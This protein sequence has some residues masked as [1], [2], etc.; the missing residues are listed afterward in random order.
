MRIE[1]SLRVVASRCCHGVGRVQ[2]DRREQ[3]RD[4]REELRAGAECAR[5]LRELDYPPTTI[6]PDKQGSK[7]LRDLEA[8]TKGGEQ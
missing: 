5:Q 1:P 8:K 4:R 3:R 2:R 7:W 6:P